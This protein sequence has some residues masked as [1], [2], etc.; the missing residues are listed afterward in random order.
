MGPYNNPGYGNQGIGPYNNPGHGNQ[1]M[2]PY[3]NPGYGQGNSNY[4]GYNGVER[5]ANPNYIEVGKLILLLL[6][7][8]NQDQMP[9]NRF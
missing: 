9:V 1:G 8:R 7:L 2:G 5:R 4:Y 3:N 6:M